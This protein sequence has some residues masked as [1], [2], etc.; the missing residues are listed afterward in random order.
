MT[1]QRT[2]RYSLPFQEVSTRGEPLT[3]SFTNGV[4]HD[5]RVPETRSA[6]PNGRP[7]TLPSRDVATGQRSPGGLVSPWRDSCG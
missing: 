6:V 2:E 7:L 3:S 1:N 4:T 5:P